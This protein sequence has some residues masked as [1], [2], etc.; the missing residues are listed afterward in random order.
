MH[1]HAG[2][3]RGGGGQRR[4]ERLALAG[5]H[6]GEHAV[7]HDAA[8]DQ[9][10]RVVAQAEQR[11]AAARTS[12][13]ERPTSS[14]VNPLPSSATR[15]ASAASRSFPSVKPVGAPPAR[16]PRRPRRPPRAAAP[17][18]N[19]RLSRAPAVEQHAVDARLALVGALRVGRGGPRRPRARRAARRQTLKRAR[20][21]CRMRRYHCR[22]SGSGL[23]REAHV[24]AAAEPGVRRPGGSSRSNWNVLTSALPPLRIARIGR[25]SRRRPRSTAPRSAT[26]P[27]PPAPRARRWRDRPRRCVRRGARRR[28]SG[29]S[30]RG[31]RRPGTRRRGPAARLLRDVADQ[32]RPCGRS[33]PADRRAA[34]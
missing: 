9:L 27:S 3:R 31:R 22:A 13:N 20:K 2:Q 14:G 7:Q 32:L 21:A 25:R 4:R 23:V 18:A 16:A 19:G 10:H 15:S 17:S 5:L 6:F 11:C 8:A 34:R 12:A 28:A 30:A 29:G 1:R 33:G 24:R 26:G